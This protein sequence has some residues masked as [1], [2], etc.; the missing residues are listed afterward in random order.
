ML[1]RND[2]YTVV[3]TS[4]GQ[5][6]TYVNEEGYIGHN[7]QDF[8]ERC[9]YRAAVLRYVETTGFGVCTRDIAIKPGL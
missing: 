2:E 7:S 1:A 3:H 9:Q 5:N 4:T 6:L 8:L